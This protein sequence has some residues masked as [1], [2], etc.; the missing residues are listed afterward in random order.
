MTDSAGYPVR[1]E[2]VMIISDVILKSRVPLSKAEIADLTRLSVMTVGKVSDELYKAGLVEMTKDGGAEAGRKA[3]LFS[4]NPKV[5]IAAAELFE[6]HI[7]LS[8]YSLVPELQK[9][10]TAAVNTKDGRA[11]FTAL[12]TL[13]DNMKAHPS[14][15]VILADDLISDAETGRLSSARTSAG[16]DLGELISGALMTDVLFASDTQTAEAM[17]EAENIDGTVFYI[18]SSSKFSRVISGGKPQKYG[19]ISLLGFFPEENDALSFIV[20]ATARLCL[21]DIVKIKTKNQE[22]FRAISAAAAPI[23]TEPA[24]KDPLSYPVKIARERLVR[25]LIRRGR[26]RGRKL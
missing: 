12:R 2:N 1:P 23:K 22:L 15:C 10:E 26:N 13:C 24:L 20:S 3:V 11:I 25:R 17:S 7:A 16:G 19:D 18:N 21:A 6:G 5:Q 4:P 14:C 8:L 9:K